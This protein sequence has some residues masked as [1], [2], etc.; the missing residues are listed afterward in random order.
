MK[1]KL[2]KLPKN[3]RE[4]IEEETERKKI[5]ELLDTKKNVEMEIKGEKVEYKNRKTENFR[6]TETNEIKDRCH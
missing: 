6:E 5:K 3:E 2:N 1:H 4:K